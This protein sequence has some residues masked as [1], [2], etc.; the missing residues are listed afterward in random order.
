MKRKKDKEL[1]K[2]LDRL[3]KIPR[4]SPEYIEFKKQ[5]RKLERIFH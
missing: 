4:H 1:E 3:Q 5:V 2:F